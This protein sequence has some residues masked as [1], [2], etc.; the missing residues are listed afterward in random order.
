MDT[1]MNTALEQAYER[2]TL[3]AHYAKV[4]ASLTE[5][6]AIK[7][8]AAEIWAREIGHPIPGNVIDEALGDVLSAMDEAELG[9]L[10]ASFAAGPADFGALLISQVD[11]YLQAR[12]RAKAREQ[13]EREL[14][15][16]EAEAVADRMAA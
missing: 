6:E 16:A 3:S 15:Q 14:V 4:D 8:A 2:R 5:D 7:A 11:G 10:G 1:H 13:I 12:C 9:E